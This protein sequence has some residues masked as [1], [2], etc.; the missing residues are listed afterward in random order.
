MANVT[1]GPKAGGGW[2]V[3]G[4]SRDFKTQAEAV[5]AGRRRLQGSGGGELVVKGRDG[6][7]RAQSTIG[8]A[9]PRR[10]TG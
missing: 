6:R 9:D 1:V 4:E 3:S 2:Q 5:Q 8:R 7:I 10:S